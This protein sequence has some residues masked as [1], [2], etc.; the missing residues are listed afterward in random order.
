V[1]HVKREIDQGRHLADLFDYSNPAGLKRALRSLADL[2]T[3]AELGC[4]TSTAILVDMKTALGFYSTDPAAA[5]RVL[6]ARQR[7]AILLHLVRDR[8]VEETARCLG[9]DPS[10]VSHRVNTGLRRMVKFLT[11]G[12]AS[13][14]EWE[15]WEVAFLQTHYHSHGAGYCAE[16]LE[17]RV[18]QVYSKVRHLLPP[19]AGAA[20]QK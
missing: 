1:A 11:T 9:I 6:T 2:Q 8:S 10:A 15:D 13:S 16:V 4:P 18:S 7:E 19:P 3:Q 14:R 17:R 5:R 20:G 12:D